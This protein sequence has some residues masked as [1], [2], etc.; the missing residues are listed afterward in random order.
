MPKGGHNRKPKALKVIHG[1]ARKDRNPE[2]EPEVR[3]L[4]E[5]P[6]PPTGLN[7][8]ARKIWKELAPEL[9]DNGVLSHVDVFAFEM[10]CTQYGI[11]K[12]LE[13]RI[14]HWPVIDR[15]TGEVIRVRKQSIA[16]YLRGRNSQTMPEYAAMRQAVAQ[17][18]ALVEQFGLT[19]ASRNRIDLPKGGENQE[20]PM[21]AL[22]NGA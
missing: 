1:T 2:N 13:Y 19:P 16:D 7:R 4:T 18:K 11:A 14:T 3:P 10:C 21:E 8:W 15:E 9:V 20:D 17:F 12:E 22:I 6:K 5:V